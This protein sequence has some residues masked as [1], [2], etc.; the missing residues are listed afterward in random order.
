MALQFA[1][2]ILITILSFFMTRSIRRTSLDYWTWAWLCLAV[3]LLSIL[4]A[5]RV[6]E[7]RYIILPLYFLGEYAFGY[8]FA[9]GCRNRASSIRLQRRDLRILIPGALL[10]LALTEISRYSTI[11]FAPHTVIVAGLFVTAYLALQPAHPRGQSRPGFRVMSMALILLT[12][13]FVQY[14]IVFTYFW[15][16]PPV[17][18]VYIQ[19]A[20]LCSLI[21]QMLLGFGTVMVVMEDVREEIEATNRELTSAR[22]RLEVL[23]RMDPLTEA[24]NRHAFYSLLE[25][26][27]EAP[28]GLGG[29]SAIVVDIDNLKP[30]NDSIGHAA[31]DGAIR[32]VASVIRSVIRAND[33]LFR[34]GGD[35]FLIL[36]F[37]VTEEDARGRIGGLNRALENLTLPGAREPVQITFSFGVARFDALTQIERA[38]DQADSQMYS[39]KQEHKI[40]TGERMRSVAP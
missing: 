25:R 20:P 9:A 30:I 32:A 26:T 33:L 40:N 14:A 18:V 19:F 15:I 27:T 31:G 6:R 23:A 8:M 39:S 36:L 4:V 21:L 13:N 38:I 5:F 28:M 1:G 11:G 16:H 10:A 3:A 22:D 37:G 29:G 17:P 7:I 24:L 35:E 12:L 34:W 2:V